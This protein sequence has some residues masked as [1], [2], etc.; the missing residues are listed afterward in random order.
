MIYILY[1]ISNGIGTDLSK[2]IQ[3]QIQQP[4][5]AE[6]KFASE[7]VVRGLT[8]TIQCRAEGDS[9]LRVE[10]NR[11]MQRIDSSQNQ[12]YIIKEEA[13]RGSITSFLEILDARRM[14]SA[15]FTCIISNDYGSDRTDIQLIVEGTIEKH[16]NI[17]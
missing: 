1:Q 12:R 11:D 4:P 6:T 2:V 15:L 10:W 14:D 7:S 8:A 9:V 3:I 17:I 13:T 5:R 16:F